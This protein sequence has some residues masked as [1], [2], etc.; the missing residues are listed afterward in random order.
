MDVRRILLGQIAFRVK[1]ATPP[2]PDSPQAHRIARSLARVLNQRLLQA[3]MAGKLPP[4]PIGAEVSNIR[5]GSLV[6]RLQLHAD[7][8]CEYGMVAA[9][10]AFATVYP[11]IKKGVLELAAGINIVAANVFGALAGTVEVQM[12]EEA[13]L[14]QKQVEASLRC[15]SRQS[16]VLDR[17]QQPVYN[18]KHQ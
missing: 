3:S 8:S 18:Q 10:K 16:T 13:L 9:F 11:D 15:R 2:N 14:S 5:S 4:Y 6:A 17:C 1:I 7:I 12:E